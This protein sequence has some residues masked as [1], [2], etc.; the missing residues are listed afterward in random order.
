MGLVWSGEE[1]GQ[2]A[3]QPEMNNKVRSIQDLKTISNDGRILRF[4]EF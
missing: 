1:S 3:K 4:G 2:K